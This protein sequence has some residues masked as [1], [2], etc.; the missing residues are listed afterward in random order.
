[1]DM[2]TIVGCENGACNPDNSCSCNEGFELE[3][4][5]KFCTIKCKDGYRAI[6]GICQPFCS[7]Y[8]KFF[9]ANKL[10]RK[11]LRHLPKI[12]HHLFWFI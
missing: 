7:R 8:F 12:F 5:G 9:L 2:V 6:N 11:H 4:N 10:F 3:P 1:M